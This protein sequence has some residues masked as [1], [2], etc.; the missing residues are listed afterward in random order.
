MLSPEPIAA[1]LSVDDIAGMSDAELAQFME[2]HRCP[3]G[4]YDL[5][6]DGWD[7]RSKDERNELAGQLKRQE[8]I[9]ARSPT[10]CSRPLDARLRD[11]PP[12]GNNISSQARS[13][14][15]ERSR[16][17]ARPR[18]LCG[19]PRPRCGTRL[20]EGRLRKPL[21]GRNRRRERSTH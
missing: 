6:I 14:V 1:T 13:Q 19:L 4:D 21:R 17:P 20:K 12:D 8:R 9:L 3:D 15:T 18:N 2:K 16:S 10:A 7:K 11:I 5:P